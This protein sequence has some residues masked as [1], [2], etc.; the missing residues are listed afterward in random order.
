MNAL[1]HPSS[2]APSSREFS[3][4]ENTI[5][6]RVVGCTG[7]SNFEAS[8]ELGCWSLALSPEATA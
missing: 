3:S 7:S 2:Q 6:V 4:E 8:P 1:K 5:A